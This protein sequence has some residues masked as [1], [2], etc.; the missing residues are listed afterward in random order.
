[1]LFGVGMH[2]LWLRAFL[3]AT[4]NLDKQHIITFLQI[5]IFDH[6]NPQQLKIKEDV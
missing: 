5:V 2:K 1:M 4:F 6:Q 3:P